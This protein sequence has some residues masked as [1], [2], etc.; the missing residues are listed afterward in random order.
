MAVETSSQAAVHNIIKKG[1]YFASPP[2]AGCSFL[3][4]RN[5]AFIKNLKEKNLCLQ[6]TCYN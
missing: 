2:F 1:Y 3:C 5:M 6:I 4:D